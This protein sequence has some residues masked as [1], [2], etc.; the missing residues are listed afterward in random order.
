MT[1]AENLHAIR[2][3][4]PD[5][6]KL[7]A[8]SKTYP[9]NVLMEAYHAGQRIFGENRVQEMVEKYAQM[10]ADVQW[11]LIGH[12]QKNKV[13]YIAPFVS[14]IHAIDSTELLQVVN[15]EAAKAQRTIPCLIQLHIA[16]EESKFG[17][18]YPEAKEFFLNKP[19]SSLENIRIAGL[20]GMASL[21]DN[22][23]QVRQEF[24][25]L[26][27]FFNEVKSGPMHTETG[28]T[29]LSMGMSSDYPI[30]IDQGAT[31]IRV[32]SAIFK[33]SR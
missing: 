1:V 20:M 30:A 18:S 6:V 8:V 27:S 15:R 3:K 13:K 9:A 28:F 31:I 21:T 24:K 11:H 12:L 17:F 29:E 5:K 19:F 22:P 14:M 2:Q 26:A 32:G 25:K 10:P 23:D 7:V 33:S 4:L 16:Q